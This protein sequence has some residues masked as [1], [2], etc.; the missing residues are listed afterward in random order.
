MTSSW[1][2]IEH[3]TVKFGS[4][5]ALRDVTLSLGAG[6]AA[7]LGRNGAG[8]T[9]LCRVIAGDLP[10]PTRDLF[11]VGVPSR[12]TGPFPPGFRRLVGSR[13]AQPR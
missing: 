1:L 8:K 12:L 7:P 4:R 2:E 11:T 13:S 9:T 3:V 10:P 5:H 6:V